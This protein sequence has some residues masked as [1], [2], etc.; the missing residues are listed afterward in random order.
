MCALRL[1]ARPAVHGGVCVSSVCGQGP[2]SSNVY[3]AA[4]KGTM[5]RSTVQ[6]RHK[7]K[8]GDINKPVLCAGGLTGRDLIS[9]DIHLLII[10]IHFGGILDGIYEIKKQGKTPSKH[11]TKK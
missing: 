10:E 7:H 4:V 9:I 5:T 3:V 11:E 2:L 6:G 1:G 8:G